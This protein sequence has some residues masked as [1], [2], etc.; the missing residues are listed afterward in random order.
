MEFADFLVLEDSSILGDEFC[1]RFG[2]HFVWCDNRARPIEPRLSAA[3]WKPTDMGTIAVWAFFILWGIGLIQSVVHRNLSL[4]FNFAFE[5]YVVRAFVVGDLEPN[6]KTVLAAMFGCWLMFI[7]SCI[8]RAIARARQQA[9]W[10]R[11]AKGKL[12]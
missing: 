11:E 10:E 9:R 4:A 6:W 3:R 8:P 2:P 5:M 12:A 1:H 7:L